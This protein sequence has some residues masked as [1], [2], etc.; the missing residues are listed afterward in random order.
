MGRQRIEL[1]FKAQTP[2]KAADQ[3]YTLA[4]YRLALIFYFDHEDYAN[5]KAAAACQVP[6]NIL[7]SIFSLIRTGPHLAIKRL[8]LG[9]SP[10]TFNIEKW[11]LNPSLGSVE[12]RLNTR[13]AAH[14]I[15]P[16]GRAMRMTLLNS[17]HRTQ[18]AMLKVR[19]DPFS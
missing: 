10:L 4:Q 17:R 3:D 15:D 12:P 1:L 19:C 11:D 18:R 5:Y 2:K 6:L 8:S 14:N 9:N 13:P 7:A 16:S